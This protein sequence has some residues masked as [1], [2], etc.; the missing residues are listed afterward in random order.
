MQLRTAFP[1]INMSRMQLRTAFLDVKKGRLHLQPWVFDIKKGRLHVQTAVL[2]RI[3][4]E[5]WQQG[6]LPSG[7]RHTGISDYLLWNGDFALII[8]SP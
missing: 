6:L 8:K 3:D 7:N 4:G 1:E 5:F 2:D